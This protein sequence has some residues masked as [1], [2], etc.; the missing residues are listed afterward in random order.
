MA[1]P[2]PSPFLS[3]NNVKDKHAGAACPAC[4]NDELLTSVRVTY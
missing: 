4:P 3:R 1:L 2:E